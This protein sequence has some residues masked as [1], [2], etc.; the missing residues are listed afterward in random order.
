MLRNEHIWFWLVPGRGEG[1]E[2]YSKVTNH[3]R[4]TQDTHYTHLPLYEYNCLEKRFFLQR[5]VLTITMFFALSL[6]DLILGYNFHCVTGTAIKHLY[7]QCN[8]PV[9]KRLSLEDQ[10]MALI[11]KECHRQRE[12]TSWYLHPHN[13]RGRNVVVPAFVLVFNMRDLYYRGQNNNIII[14]IL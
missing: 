9:F 8:G 5:M 12:R 6:T 7:T 2:R 3:A 11:E 14:I 1:E 13:P 4:C 10:H